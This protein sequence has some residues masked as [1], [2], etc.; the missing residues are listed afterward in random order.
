VIVIVTVVMIV[1]MVMTGF[2]T[3]FLRRADDLGRLLY[4]GRGLL[5]HFDD[6]AHL[7]RGLGLPGLFQDLGRPLV[8]AQMVSAVADPV[9]EA[10]DGLLQIVHVTP[11]LFS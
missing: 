6:P 2:M 3:D 10:N 11:R 5:F 8:I 9:M 7:G 4:V 1:A